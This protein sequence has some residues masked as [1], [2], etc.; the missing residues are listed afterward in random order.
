MSDLGP[1]SEPGVG[2]VCTDC[3]FQT[4][5]EAKADAH[6]ALTGHLI[7]ID[8]MAFESDWPKLPRSEGLA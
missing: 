3:D 4:A 7:A 8:Y 1:M 5:S 6:Y 2:L